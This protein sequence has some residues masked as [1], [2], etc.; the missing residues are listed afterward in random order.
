[1]MYRCGWATKPGQEHVLAVRITRGGSG[2]ILAE[3]VESN[4]HPE[5]HGADRDAWQRAAKSPW[6]AW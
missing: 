1:M 5:V 2:T 4:H 6:F 3:A